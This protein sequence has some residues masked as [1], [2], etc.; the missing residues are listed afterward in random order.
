MPLFAYRARTATGRSERGLVDAES[1]RGAW[2][3]LRG[4]GVFPTDLRAGAADAGDRVDAAELAEATR[5][6]ASLATAGVPIADALDGVADETAVP[7]LRRAFTVVRARVREGTTLA[8]ALGTCPRVFPPLYRELVRAGEASGALDAVLARLA[9]DG[10]AAAARR[11]RLRAALAYPAV[12]VTMTGLVLV[13]LLV[14][15]VPEVARLFAETGTALPLA[16]RA[17]L[18]AAAVVRTTWWLWT[19]VLVGGALAIRRWYA[20]APGRHA[21]DGLVLRLP[22]VGRAVRVRATGRVARTLATVLANG[23]PLDRALG[24]AAATAGNARVTEAIGGVRDAVRRGE[25]LAPALAR[26][27]LFPPTLGRL[28]ATGERT[29][30][31]PEAFERA[32]TAHEDEIERTLAAAT[33]LVEPALVVLVGIAV[34]ALVLAILVP[35]LT[36]D[37]LGASR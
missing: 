20:T 26:H 16:T 37:P 2:Q 36:L 7:A 14:W 4:R 10:A 3:E 32:A 34:L 33:A 9:R 27:G 18:A 30:A 24:L 17:L 5:Q 12:M 21:L 35:I 8:D 6:L 23:L 29:G 1:V 31:L 22:V 11:A 13:F 15:V 25:A 19:A 28:V